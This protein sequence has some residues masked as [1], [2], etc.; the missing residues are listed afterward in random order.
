MFRRYEILSGVNVFRYMTLY[1]SSTMKM[2]AAG[3]SETLARDKKLRG[4]A[5]QNAHDEAL[6]LAA[7]TDRSPFLH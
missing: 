2:E 3:W 1:I 5:S 7:V 6:R 4:L